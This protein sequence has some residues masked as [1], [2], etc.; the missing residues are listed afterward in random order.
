MVR[1]HY[2][3]TLF[4][5]AQLH[6]PNVNDPITTTA[7]PDT[8]HQLPR[9][10]NTNR[11]SLHTSATHGIKS[12]ADLRATPSSCF[13]YIKNIPDKDFPDLGFSE[14]DISSSF[15]RYSIIYNP[16]LCL[17]FEAM[18][19]VT[20]SLSFTAAVTYAAK[21]SSTTTDTSI[22][23]LLGGIYFG[24]VFFDATLKYQPE[25]ERSGTQ[26][27]EKVSLIATRIQG[28]GGTPRGM[29]NSYYDIFSRR[30]RND[31]SK[32][33]RQKRWCVG[34]MHEYEISC[35]RRPQSEGNE[36]GK[37]KVVPPTQDDGG[38][39]E[40]ALTQK[41]EKNTGDIEKTAK[42]NGSNV[43]CDTFSINSTSNNHTEKDGEHLNHSADKYTNEAYVKDEL[44]DEIKTQ[45]HTNNAEINRLGI[46]KNSSKALSEAVVRMNTSTEPKLFGRCDVIEY[47]KHA[48]YSM[49][50]GSFVERSFFFNDVM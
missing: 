44:E 20:S 11:S 50:T 4:H 28:P 12:S 16:W 21:L 47:Q 15:P 1:S 9:T 22:Q 14:M 30:A 32:T 24:V 6:I 17:V 49:A 3:Q 29:Y 23:G 42:S 18:E 36:I 19:S 7:Q 46:Y 13:S 8:S 35:F 45:T 31:T 39:M 26:R 40:I 34:F 25:S 27:F 10:V 5:C 37:K 43:E 38:Q 41:G 2:K 48:Q 33:P